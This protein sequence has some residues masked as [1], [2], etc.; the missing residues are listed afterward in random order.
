M[1]KTSLRVYEKGHKYYKSSDCPI[2]PIC[3]KSLNPENSFLSLLASPARSALESNGISSL[4]SLSCYTEKELMNLYGFGRASI[5]ILRKT[6][7]DAGLQ[8]K[9]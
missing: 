2:C 9:K 6:L 7:K 5:P 4:K 3:S 8:F 1:A